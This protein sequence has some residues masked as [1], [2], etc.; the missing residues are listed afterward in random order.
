MIVKIEYQSEGP[1]H[2]VEE[3]LENYDRVKRPTRESISIE[4]AP[5]ARIVISELFGPVL[6]LSPAKDVQDFDP[7]TEV[8]VFIN[9]EKLSFPHNNADCYGVGHKDTVVVTITHK[10]DVITNKFILTRH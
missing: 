8:T 9:E 10:E 7:K 2:S 5:G 1:Y 6:W 4:V 3:M